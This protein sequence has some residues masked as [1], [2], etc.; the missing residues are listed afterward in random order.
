MALGEPLLYLA[1]IDSTNNECKRQALRGAK[2][3]LAILAGKQSQG[4]GRLGRSFQSLEGK[5]LY[6]SVL[7]RPQVGLATAA[8]FTAWAAVAVCR[9]LEKEL[10]LQADIK[11]P[12]DILVRGK[13]L[14]GILTEGVGQALVLGM[15]VN[16]TQTADDFGSELK[17]IAISLAELGYAIEREALARAILRE[18]DL[19]YAQFPAHAQPC[20]K[21]FRRRCVTL[22]KPVTLLRGEG[23]LP[24]F[25]LDV[26]ENFG[27]VVERE[28]QREIVTSGE[29]SVRER[30]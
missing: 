6:L 8:Q 21:E 16:L 5:G 29:V 26:A 19:L 15:G 11:W 25:A 18:L 20:L 2:E 17:D 9:A 12:N 4:K 14:C 7:L 22:G 27:L 28:G 23:S 1:E 13:K 30:A 3:G 24:A 10:G